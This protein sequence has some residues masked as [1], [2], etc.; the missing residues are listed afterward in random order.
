MPGD[1]FDQ[2]MRAREWLEGEGNGDPAMGFRNVHPKL[3]AIA[4][5]NCGMVYS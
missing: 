3:P 5:V 2:V 1:L 4:A